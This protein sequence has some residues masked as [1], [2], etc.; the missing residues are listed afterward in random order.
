M[1]GLLSVRIIRGKC[2]RWPFQYDD[3]LKFIYVLKNPLQKS[4][5]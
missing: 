2:Y 3:N 1:I 4:N 5:N